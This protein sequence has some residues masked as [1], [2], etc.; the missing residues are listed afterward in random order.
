MRKIE[1]QEI[2][3]KVS[4]EAMDGKR[5]ASE[6]LCREYES[7]ATVSLKDLLVKYD[8]IQ[9]EALIHM[10]ACIDSEDTE[11]AHDSADRILCGVLQAVGFKNLVEAYGKVEKWYS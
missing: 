8:R 4:Y 11:A 6:E 7:T 10:Q 9:D 1:D 2:V 3:T 5:F